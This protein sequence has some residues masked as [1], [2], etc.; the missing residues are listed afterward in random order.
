[1]G[2]IFVIVSFLFLCRKKDRIDR[3]KAF[4][5]LSVRQLHPGC[6]MHACNQA[7]FFD[8]QSYN[9]AGKHPLPRVHVLTYS[10][11]YPHTHTP[12]FVNNKSHHP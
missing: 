4:I 7:F 2:Y 9:M 1:M 6:E 12:T 10:H 8:D 5:G 11:T 3:E